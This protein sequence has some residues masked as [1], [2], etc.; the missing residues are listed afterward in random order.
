[1]D[2]K[3]I[4]GYAEEA[5]LWSTLALNSW[6]ILTGGILGVIKYVRRT[7]ISVDQVVI[8]GTLSVMALVLASG[9]LVMSSLFIPS[10]AGSS[11][12]FWARIVIFVFS[13]IAIFAF[14][15]EKIAAFHEWRSRR[16]K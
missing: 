15:N 6:L 11:V 13:V 16:R 9:A 3:T 1:M 8:A 7:P 4:H 10:L 2:W 14:I 5:E 12:L